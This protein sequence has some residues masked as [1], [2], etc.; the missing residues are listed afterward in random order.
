MK[1]KVSFLAVIITIAITIAVTA[2]PLYARQS[3]PTPA[4]AQGPV[5]LDQLL[6][7]I[8][9]REAVFADT[10]PKFH[11][12]IETYIQNLDGSEELTF[13][14]KSD[15]Y[16][17]G[18]LDV[19]GNKKQQS[20]MPQPGFAQNMMKKLTQFP[21]VRYMPD[22]F[23][24][25]L[26]PG[27]GFNRDNYSFEYVRR[28]FLGEVRCLVFD[29]KPK[30]EAKGTFSGRI[31]VED[32]DYNI[33]RFNGSNGSSSMTK[34]F[35][36]FDSWRENMGPGVWMP[37]YVYS[38]ESDLGYFFGRRKLRFKAQTRVWGYNVEASRRQD[39]L[40]ALTVESDQVRDN[41]N[42]T[43]ST[44]PVGAF[45]AWEH[46][47]EDNI[48]HRLEKAALLAPL[49]EVNK[50]LETV[51]SNLQ[52]TNNLDIYREVRARVLL[53]SPVESFTIGHTIVLSRGMIDVL[54]DEASLAMILA[55]E[56]AHIMLGH[57]IDT[58]YAF[59]D[60]MFF[61]DED[62]FR[63]VRLKRK[64]K[65]ELEADKQAVEYLKNSP[66]K[67]KLSNAGLFLRAVNERAGQLT[68]LL[69]PHIGNTMVKG[70]TVTRMADLIQSA[71]QLEMKKLDQIAALPLGGRVRLDAWTGR[72]ELAKSNPV[73]LQFA[74][75][76]M[77][78]EV[79]P[80]F[81]YLTRQRDAEIGA[82]QAAATKQDN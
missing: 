59:N 58:K 51:I 69:L 75:E 25:M 56:L 39:E 78:F 22:G 10:L 72:I 6:D 27:K 48:I 23:A 45:R 71:P 64:E 79:T 33:V 30:R 62:V 3:A 4:P 76:K 52:V 26:I 17:I 60:R 47:A 77:P 73:P 67:D 14:P 74:R 16:F 11:P 43:E 57:R 24:Q 32:R 63:G 41:I 80:V 5:P 13:V 66:Y 61:E 35:F 12:L 42:E 70:S 8:I 68:H 65:E 29:V 50:V 19:S 36:H 1:F 46:Q 53:T 82:A 21:S 55:H 34:I 81:L 37:S 20:F 40:T 2:G 31:W 44:S 38:E 28:E 15:S 18:K 9:A 49:G 54:P 7:K